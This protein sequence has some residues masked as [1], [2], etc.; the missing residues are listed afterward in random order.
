[1]SSDYLK[2]AGKK[3]KFARTQLGLSQKQ[4]GELLKISD[5][6]ISSYEVGRADPGLAVMSQIG[7]LVH[8]PLSYFD[9]EA[10]P[11]DISEIDARL[12]LAEVEKDLLEIKRSLLQR[13]PK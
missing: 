8:R 4:M 6:T 2:Q 13:R 5:K 1:M 11:S 3:I 12:K 7:K 9:D 10:D